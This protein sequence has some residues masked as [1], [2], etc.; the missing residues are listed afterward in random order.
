[1]KNP[2]AAQSLE[3]DM[4]QST[5]NRKFIFGTQCDIR[6][7]HQWEI[8]DTAGGRWKQTGI[9]CSAPPAYPWSHLVLEFQRNSTQATFISVTLNGHKSYI[10]RTYNTME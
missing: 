3:F 6:D 1:L 4:N 2:G 8:W 10:S 7:S 5:N 9:G